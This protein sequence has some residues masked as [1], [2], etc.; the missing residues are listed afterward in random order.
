VNERAA[1]VFELRERRGEGEVAVPVRAATR[2]DSRAGRISQGKRGAGFS[3]VV[4][5]FG[6]DVGESSEDRGE[7]SEDRGESSEDS[8]ELSEDRGE[9]EDDLG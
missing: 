3:D 7:S 1:A 8:G 4:G 2:E 6:D 5:K 9:L